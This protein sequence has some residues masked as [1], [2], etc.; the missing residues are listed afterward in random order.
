MSRIRARLA[1]LER[2][3]CGRFRKPLAAMT[4]AE[5]QD[6]IEAIDTATENEL[7]FLL[8]GEPSP[9]ELAA[10]MLAGGRGYG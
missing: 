4:E 6:A 5:L 1:R 9:D 2:I 10:A 7:V 3:I 8:G